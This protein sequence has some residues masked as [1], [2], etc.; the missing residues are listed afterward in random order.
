[1]NIKKRLSGCALGSAIGDALG[2]PLEFGPA[3]PEDNLIRQMKAGRLSAGSFTDDTEMA[4]AL[5]ESLAYQH[6]LDPNDLSERFVAWLKTNPPDIGLHTRSALGYIAQGK[7]WSETESL[8]LKIKPDSAGNGSIMRCWP[9]AITWW[10]HA[11][12]LISD[13]QLQSRV[14]HAHPDCIAGSVFVNLM[15]SEFVKG[16]NRETGLDY[17][18]KHT[19]GLS[20]DFKA[21]ISAAPQR[22]RFELLNTGWVRHTIES[23]VWG[24]LNFGSFTETVIQVVNLGNDADT[25]GAV[26]GAIAGAL[27]GIETIP[28]DWL[29]KL[30]GQWPVDSKKTW[31]AK[32][33]CSLVDKITL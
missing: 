16:R 28:D 6:P 14:T 26:V 8:I 29:D 18:L 21:V 2:M 20:K 32:D 12:D 10:N 30:H 15:I 19:P 3:S 11:E 5:A 17:A 31:F 27:Y 9:V 7:S 23:A 24:L 4:L 25:A 22:N 33:I 13:S 1:M